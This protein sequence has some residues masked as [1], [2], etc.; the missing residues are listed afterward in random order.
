MTSPP[1]PP[2]EVQDS[3]LWT[4]LYNIG[5]ALDVFLAALLLGANLGETMSHCSA[6]RA[7]AGAGWACV[8]CRILS[9]VVEPWHCPR[10]LASDVTPKTAAMRA[11]LALT[12]L[13]LCILGTV[14]I[15]VHLVVHAIRIL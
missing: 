9:A 1:T 11:G 12:G 13:A 15:A 3:G 10:T 2:L 5:W 8:L 6:R 7:S 14:E 4:R